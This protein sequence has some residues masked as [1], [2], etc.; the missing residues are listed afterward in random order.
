VPRRLLQAEGAVI[1][2]AAVAV[3]VDAD[4]SLLALV[5]L[6]SNT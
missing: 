5:L 6:F 1:F 3:Y 4:F 2:A